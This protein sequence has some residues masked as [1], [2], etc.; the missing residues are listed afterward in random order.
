MAVRD[1]IWLALLVLATVLTISLKYF[2]YLPGDVTSTRL[3]QSV[4]PESKSWAQMVSATAQMPWVLILIAITFFCSRVI[5]GWRAAVLS[6]ASFVGL[7]LL[8]NWLGPFI[9]Q[10]R[11]SSELVQVTG[12]LSGSAFP[13]IF[14][15]NYISTVGFLAVF[16]AV[17]TSGKL[18]WAIMLIC[19]SLLIVGWIARVDLAAHWPSDVAISYLIGLLWV[20]LLIRFA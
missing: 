1:S 8:G 19:S 5:A 4:L 9:A 3:I 20:S 14:A 7:W 15:F 13:S 12:S 16:S 10:P 2:P 6:I 11:P 18:R 17:K